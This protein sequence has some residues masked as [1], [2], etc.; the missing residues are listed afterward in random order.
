LKLLLLSQLGPSANASV[1]VLRSSTTT[2]AAAAIDLIWFAL[3]RWLL[4]VLLRARVSPLQQAD[5][6]SGLSA[7][8]SPIAGTV[9]KQRI[10][11][12]ARGKQT[13]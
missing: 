5:E 4:L 9:K 7:I 1:G 13:K 8:L 3:R 2:R 10:Y 11:K 12:P 6:D